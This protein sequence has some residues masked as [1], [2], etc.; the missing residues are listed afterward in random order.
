MEAAS[1]PWRSLGDIL[2]DRGLLSEDQLEKALAEEFA[3][4]RRLADILVRRG[5]VSG[6]DITSALMEQVGQ[7]G[8]KDA[9]APRPELKAVEDAADEVPSTQQ[10]EVAASAELL[11]EELPSD[12]F[13]EQNDDFHAALEEAVVE[14]AE[15]PDTPSEPALDSA[16]AGDAQLSRSPEEVIREADQRR[17]ASESRLTM[18]DGIEDS[19]DRIRSEL[20]MQELITPP[21]AHELQATQERVDARKQSLSAEIDHLRRTRDGV[22]RTSGQLEELRTHLAGKLNDLSD[23]QTTAAMWNSRVSELETEVNSLVEQIDSIALELSKLVDGIDEQTPGIQ[24]VTE[25]HASP[26]TDPVPAD[27]AIEPSSWE[28]HLLFVPNDDSYDLVERDGP[29]PAVG[30]PIDVDGDTWIVTKIGSS[31]LPYDERSCVFFSAS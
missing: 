7:F 16:A 27:P 21:L 14:P 10:S 24:A 13:E 1:T 8:G 30:E 2:V 31:P 29:P 3:T 23:V 25:V 17:L 28:T 22:E 26:E 11:D 18:L 12:L 20:E 9:E 19:L 5:L 6:H 4:K 15:E